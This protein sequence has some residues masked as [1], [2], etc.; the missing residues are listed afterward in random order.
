M[1]G[2]NIMYCFNSTKSYIILTHYF[3]FTFIFLK[4]ELDAGLITKSVVCFVLLLP[5]DSFSSVNMPLPTQ[6]LNPG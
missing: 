1:K 6:S 4:I 3:I 2:N 5:G